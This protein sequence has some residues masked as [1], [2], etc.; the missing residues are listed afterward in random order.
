NAYVQV[1]TWNFT[2]GCGNTSANFVQTVTIQDTTAPVLQLPINATAECSSD[3]SPMALG[4]ATAKDNCDSDPV[5]TYTDVITP[6]SCS[7]NYNITRTWTATDAC[8]NSVSD[9]QIITVQDTTA[10]T[11]VETLPSDI[12]VECD[13]IPLAHT[14]TAND[15]CGS[16]TVS[17]NDVITAGSCANNYTI[18]RTWTATDEC[19][20]TTTHT[21]TITVEDTTAPTFVEALPSD[22]TVEC[23]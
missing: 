16:G 20:L 6:G 9:N 23:D 22:I 10:P 18:A 19:G 14:L 12:T 2:D 7:G 17:V 1:R 11:F 13:N 3:L 21:Q 5:I 15:N 4:T 8:G